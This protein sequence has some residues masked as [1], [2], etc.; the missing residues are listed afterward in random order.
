M[1]TQPTTHPDDM[2][3]IGHELRDE[4]SSLAHHPIDEIRRLKHVAS[5]GESPT[6]PILLTF[7]VSAVVAV[8]LAI[9]LAAAMLVY[10]FA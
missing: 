2:E 5:D 7:G 9:F 6:T 1:T 10:Y 8:A 3:L 4:V